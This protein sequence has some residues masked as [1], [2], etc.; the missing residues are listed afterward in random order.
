M[1]LSTVLVDLC[2]GKSLFLFCPAEAAR[3]TTD[4][5]FN[6]QS[7]TRAGQQ[8]AP[9]AFQTSA[10]QRS[11][12]EGTLSQPTGSDQ[13][14]LASGSHGNDPESSSHRANKRQKG[15]LGNQ[16]QAQGTAAQPEGGDGAQ[17]GFA[18][19][20][21]RHADS[22][23]GEGEGAAPQTSGPVQAAEWPCHPPNL[24]EALTEL[25]LSAKEVFAGNGEQLPSFVTDEKLTDLLQQLWVWAVQLGKVRA[26]APVTVPRLV[27]VAQWGLQRMRAGAVQGRDSQDGPTAQRAGSAPMAEAAVALGGLAASAGTER[28][29]A[30][31]EGKQQQAQH[32][33][34]QQQQQMEE[35][36]EEEPG[37][38]GTGGRQVGAGTAAAEPQLNLAGVVGAR[39]QQGTAAHEPLQPQAIEQRQ[40]QVSSEEGRQGSEQLPQQAPPAGET[41][42][43]G[44]LGSPESAA[45][46]QPPRQNLV[47]TLL[48]AWLH[49]LQSA[50]VKDEDHQGQPEDLMELLTQ[51]QQQQQQ[52]Q[53]QHQVAG[54]PGMQQPTGLQRPRPLRPTAGRPG[55]SMPPPFGIPQGPAGAQQQQLAQQQAS[56]TLP[57][58]AQGVQQPGASV[59]P[60][61]AAGRQGSPAPLMQH[62]PSRQLGM[63]LP[64]AFGALPPPSQLQPGQ[65]PT[66]ML[67]LLGDLTGAEL[68]EDPPFTASLQNSLRGFASRL[69]ANRIGFQYEPAE[70]RQACTFVVRQVTREQKQWLARD[71]EELF[72]VLLQ[73]CGL[74]Q[75]IEMKL[76]ELHDSVGRKVARIAVRE[77]Q[78]AGKGGADPGPLPGGSLAWAGGDWPGRDSGRA[79]GVALQPSPVQPSPQ[80]RHG[81]QMPSLSSWTLQQQQQ[82]HGSGVQ[83]TSA[84]DL[85]AFGSRVDRLAA[86]Q[87]G[88]DLARR[89]SSRG[90]VGDA[91]QSLQQQQRGP[92]EPPSMPGAGGGSVGSEGGGRPPASAPAAA[93]AAAAAAQDPS[94]AVV[95]AQLLEIMRGQLQRKEGQRE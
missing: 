92:H 95:A 47:G 85:Q 10:P 38:L 12:S 53:Q 82:Q 24:R 49:V 69:A 28:V 80:Q 45:G 33:Q 23:D 5:G 2:R 91:S 29:G 21:S 18:E 11:D 26:D 66:D 16:A 19:H 63:G 77:Q 55:S 87:G 54:N 68:A 9:L 6:L 46:Q 51:P 48:S 75:H 41:Q 30:E 43:A 74:V 58:V 88:R 71:T 35:Q 73:A 70:L 89:A 56:P 1:L 60:L 15:E 83:S 37:A 76:R 72:F 64:A 62:Q 90:D 79:A 84:P 14:P 40:Q 67:Y 78:G 22:G 57:T 93:A 50:A 86:L 20:K 31:V 7:G 34:Q 27:L 8:S 17:A 36:E 32:P 13:A 61:A 44:T 81:Q 52:Q 42:A 3:G 25:G 4:Q 39:R 94:V 65:Q 59:P